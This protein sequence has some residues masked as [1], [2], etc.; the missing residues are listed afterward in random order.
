[1]KLLYLLARLR[2]ACPP[3][4]AVFGVITYLGDEIAFLALALLTLWCIS[5]RGGYY[6]LA[7]GFTGTV[8]NQFLKITFRI[9]RPWK[10]DPNFE[11]WEGARDAA[12]GYSFPSGHTQNAVGTFGVL[13]HL[14]GSRLSGRLRS[15]FVVGCIGAAVAVAFSRMLLGVHTPLDVFVSIGI[16]LLLLVLGHFFF[17]RERSTGELLVAIGAMTAVAFLYVL[18]AELFP[19]PASTD[20]EN[21]LSARENAWTLF[22]AAAGVL[23]M[24]P[25]E[26]KYVRF[27]TK[28]PL[29]GQ[30]LKFTLGAALAIAE[31]ELLK[32][33]L[34]AMFGQALFPNAIRYFLL[35]LFCGCVWP[36]TFPYFAK[37][38]AKSKK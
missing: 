18:Y 3:L 19:F 17:R 16:A 22:G 26:R 10:I 20:P 30:I 36:L 15:L 14:S 38:G 1:M 9:P 24:T 28:A 37:I 11:I 29:L 8:I 2:E 25:I 21:L 33:P 23:V 32:L 4:A 5:K 34:G 12:T 27:E 6:L 13:A 7:V 31:G 35:V